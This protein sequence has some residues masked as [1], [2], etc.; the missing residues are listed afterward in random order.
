MTFF[1]KHTSAV[2]FNAQLGGAFE[3]SI[4]KNLGLTFAK[5]EDMKYLCFV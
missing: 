5:A 1:R 3:G 4:H 2:A